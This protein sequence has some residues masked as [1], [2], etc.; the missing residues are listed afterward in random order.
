MTRRIAI[1]LTGT[2]WLALAAAACLAQAR[3]PAGAVLLSSGSAILSVDA[4]PAGGDRTRDGLVREIDDPHTGRRWLLLRDSL[5]PAGPGRLI[6]AAPAPGGVDSEKAHS[7]GYA[8][9]AK[10]VILHT[11]DR[12]VLEEDTPTVTARL[13][14]VALGPAWAGGAVQ[15]RLR[16][17]GQVV[18]AVAVAPGRVS[19]TTGETQP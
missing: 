9:R 2:A 11:G 5:H 7:E 8:D 15:V 10:A 1:R 13:E 18:R 16:I 12:V 19:L 4:E 3:N 17:G 6:A 14:A